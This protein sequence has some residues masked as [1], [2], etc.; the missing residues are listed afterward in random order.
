[1][2]N[3]LD[4]ENPFR[5]GWLD[6]ISLHNFSG[7]YFPISRCFAFQLFFCQ[8]TNEVLSTP[9]LHNCCFNLRIFNTDFDIFQKIKVT[10]RQS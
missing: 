9:D 7:V 5:P 1:M 6:W 8:S 3:I 4:L 10:F 2:L